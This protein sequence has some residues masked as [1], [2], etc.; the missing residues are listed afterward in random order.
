M[1]SSNKICT[2]C[3]AE[4]GTSAFTKEVDHLQ[5]RSLIKE[6]T[7]IK[8]NES[9]SICDKCINKALLARKF[10]VRVFKCISLSQ[11][12]CTPP[13]SEEQDV[14]EVTN[15]KY[16][17]N[18]SFEIISDK[19]RN[20]NSI[21]DSF[22]QT[23]SIN[24]ESIASTKSSAS[25]ITM[26]DK[27]I[28]WNIIKDRLAE[29][30]LLKVSCPLCLLSFDNDMMFNQH[31]WTEHIELMWIEENITPKK[32]DMEEIHRRLNMYGFQLNPNN[33]EYKCTLCY[34]RN[35][36]SFGYL[37]HWHKHMGRVVYG[38]FNCKNVYIESGLYICPQN[39]SSSTDAKCLLNATSLYRVLSNRQVSSV[40]RCVECP[41]IFSATD[42]LLIH[43]ETRHQDKSRRCNL[44]YKEFDSV[45]ELQDHRKFC[46]VI[47]TTLVC[48][49]CKLKYAF[50]GA[51]V[52][53]ILH[54]H[55]E[56][57]LMDSTRILLYGPK[58]EKF[59]C[60]ICK[61]KYSSQNQLDHHSRIHLQYPERYKCYICKHKFL[62]A[63]ALREHMKQHYTTGT[64]YPCIYCG[65]N[66]HKLTDLIAHIRQHSGNSSYQFS[67]TFTH[68]TIPSRRT[69]IPFSPFEDDDEGP[70][71]KIRI[72]CCICEKQFIEVQDLHRHQDFHQHHVC[73]CNGNKNTH[74][75]ATYVSSRGEP[76]PMGGV[77][78]E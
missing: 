4:E 29:T 72:V 74:G 59:E 34:E 42:K 16:V 12:I 9:D 67:K 24:S 45:D 26:E 36:S 32:L 23:G 7:G 43:F 28:S 18:D 38:C 39:T 1:T 68:T 52:K 5:L 11:S 55:K 75:T 62:S 19:G 70:A 25:D 47:V 54:H 2:T 40:H 57:E 76:S 64:S 69:S 78:Q 20:E 37:Q 17:V 44:C 56:R 71:S 53:H 61:K 22:I 48:P 35:N 10:K 8:I 13:P 50:K 33:P 15:D 31:L 60:H 73:H 63:G 41:A 58:A 21:L 3:L 66:Y 49:L 51:L 65:H 14:R 27:A 46:E 30:D 77:A 6:S